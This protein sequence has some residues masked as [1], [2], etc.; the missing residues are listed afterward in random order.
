MYLRW[1][2]E[3][4]ITIYLPS[5]LRDF[6]Q[7]TIIFGEKI[8]ISHY[9]AIL[10][11]EI[12]IEHRGVITRWRL[13]VPIGCN[14]NAR[15]VRSEPWIDSRTTLPAARRCT[16]FCVAAPLKCNSE[17][18][19]RA[20]SVEREFRFSSDISYGR[21]SHSRHRVWHGVKFE[22]KRRKRQETPLFAR[23]G[24]NLTGSR[25]IYLVISPLY[26]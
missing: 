5:S 15:I 19:P 24:I 20:A 10:Q 8:P 3:I 18:R 17:R 9:K 11:L 25:K 23:C 22:T 4:T 6:K 2:A 13:Y 1:S 21:A 26:N 12:Y 16:Y 7:E 14:R